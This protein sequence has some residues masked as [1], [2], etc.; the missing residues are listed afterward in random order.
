[1]WL[2]PQKLET[3]I[4]GSLFGD[5]VA[6]TDLRLVIGASAENGGQGAVYVYRR[7]LRQ[8]WV[9]QQRLDPPQTGY[10]DGRVR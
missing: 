4:P 9:L 7:G 10:D 5:G 3:G 6:T 1:M 2:A 8:A